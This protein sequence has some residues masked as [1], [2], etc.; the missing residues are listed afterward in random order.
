MVAGKIRITKLFNA[1]DV[2]LYLLEKNIVMIPLLI[3]MRI[4]NLFIPVSKAGTQIL[5]LALNLKITICQTYHLL[6]EKF[7]KKLN[8][9]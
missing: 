8:F 7:M 2:I 9:L 1:M 4:T 5:L 3:L 6:V